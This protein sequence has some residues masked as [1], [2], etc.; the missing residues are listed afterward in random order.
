MSSPGNWGSNEFGHYDPNTR[1]PG[2]SGSQPGMQYQ[3][4]GTFSQ[5]QQPPQSPPPPPLSQQ[6][7]YPGMVS[8][9]PAQPAPTPPGKSRGPMIAAI[10]L[11]SVAVIA[12]VTTIVVLSTSDGGSQAAP[13]PPA[14]TS[15]P[16]KPTPSATSAA[17]PTAANPQLTPLV[18]GWQVATVPKR[19]AVYDVPMNWKLD[20]NPEG[21]HG[22]GPPDD[23]VTMTGVAEYQKG[24]C[25]GAPTSY[26]A[27]SGATARRGPDDTA[28]AT[29]TLQKFA[30]VAYTRAGQAPV[31]LPGPPEQLQLTGG[32]PAV[33]ITA[34]ITM[35]SP[36]TCD[37]ATVAVSVL[38]TNNDGQ[39]SVV[40]IA[41]S[42]Q[43]VPDSVPV[44]TLKQITQSFRGAPK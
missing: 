10:A 17:P 29:E 35:P 22:F 26:R 19:G 41:A 2:A 8:G 6:Q 38:A 40:F 28:V 36:E 43:N 9:Y 25:T 27:V 34:Q 31:V 30:A 3:G 20:S 4:F 33:R 37:S 11:A 32:V 23:P 21:V 15:T 42:D 13:P 12:I 14:V 7:P 1:Q 16:S 39:S 24:F 18:P 44:D 5:P